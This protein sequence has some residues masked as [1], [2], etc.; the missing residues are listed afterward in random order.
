VHHL[1]QSAFELPLVVVR[2]VIMR[3]DKDRQVIAL[4]G[5]E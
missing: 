4:S 5:L 1:F 2:K 3:L